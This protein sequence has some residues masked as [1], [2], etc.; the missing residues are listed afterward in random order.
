LLKRLLERHQ[1][2]LCLRISFRDGTYDADPPQTLR[3]RTRSKRPCC[4]AADQAEELASSHMTSLKE[5]QLT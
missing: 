4:R 5:D 3:L 2:W 1:A